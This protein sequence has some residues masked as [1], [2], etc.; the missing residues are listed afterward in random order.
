MRLPT[1][2]AGAVSACCARAGTARGPPAWAWVNRSVPAA[3]FP[4]P[5]S[6][7]RALC[8][9]ARPLLR[10]LLSFGINQLFGEIVVTG[11]GARAADVCYDFGYHVR[12]GPAPHDRG[13]ASR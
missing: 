7:H 6:L 3:L 5:S 11:A 4:D 10:A 2:V 13:R 1:C 8:M 9:V 12:R